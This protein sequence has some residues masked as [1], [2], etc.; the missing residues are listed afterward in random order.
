MFFVSIWLL[1]HVEAESR[2]PFHELFYGKGGS[3]SKCRAASNLYG[4]GTL[5]SGR[6]VGNALMKVILTRI[7]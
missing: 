3:N 7:G 1:P 6:P 4:A 2:A 5:V